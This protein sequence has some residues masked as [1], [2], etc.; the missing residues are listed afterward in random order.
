M[1]VESVFP[2]ERAADAH[3]QLALRSNRGKIVLTI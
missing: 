1:P 2:S 3:R